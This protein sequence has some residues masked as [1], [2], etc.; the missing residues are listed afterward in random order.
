MPTAS[1][2]NISHSQPQDDND[3][4][5]PESLSRARNEAREF[6]ARHA[7]EGQ[8]F[9][10]RGILVGLGVGLIICFSASL[11]QSYF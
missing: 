6:L 1:E 11:L 4:E 8:N 2:R 3:N 5:S 7:N 10:I 9:T